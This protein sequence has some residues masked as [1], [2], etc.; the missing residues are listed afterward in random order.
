MVNKIINIIKGHYNSW[1]GKEQELYNKRISV[2]NECDLK[3]HTTIGDICS[4]CGC[5]LQAKTRVEDEKCD[6]DKW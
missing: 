3:L 2:C 4:E 1:L 6:L 5:P